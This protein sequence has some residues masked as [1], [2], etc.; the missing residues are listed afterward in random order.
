MDERLSTPVW[1]RPARR[2]RPRAVR[3]I[4]PSQRGSIAPQE[5]A[6]ELHRRRSQLIGELRRRSEARGV[7]AQ[8]Q[9]EI[10]DDAITAV[11]MSPRA[12]ANERHLLGA[13]WLAVAHRC[14]R[15]R[16][17]R[18]LT[19]LGSRR[20]VELDLAL[21]QAPTGMSPVDS[22]EQRERFARAADL[23]AELDE[24]ERAVFAAMASN[25]VGAVTAARLLEMP[26][27]E[28]RAAARSA[29]AKLDRVAAIAAAGRMCEFRA[30]AI[31]A[32]ASGTASERQARLAKAH[33]SACVPCTSVYRRLRREMRAREF[34]R[35]AVAAFLPLPAS[36][37]AHPAGLGRTLSWLEQRLHLLPR[38]G[39]DRTLE[40]LGGAGVAKAAV[41]GTAILAAGGALGGH[42]VGSLEHAPAH[43]HARSAHVASS[44][45]PR[46]A[47]VATPAP[48]STAAT[49][50]ASTTS[51]ARRVHVV[52]SAARAPSKSLGYLALGSSSEAGH[53]NASA[54]VGAASSSTARIASASA[55][56]T[57]AESAA[58]S[59]TA[60]PAP[61]EHAAPASSGGGGTALGY[62]G[63]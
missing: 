50:S 20:R 46:T 2:R 1:R 5:A 40:A 18:H 45:R 57:S 51:T 48:T 7:P 62:L 9:E 29:A 38:G 42:V 24:R 61:S 4:R 16:E 11:V 13:F 10:I 31:G 43:H 41:A 52:R 60:A 14:R 39:G 55:S 58:S 17:G 23:I 54:Q 44:A 8:A 3:V 56:A 33:L 37:A 30:G 22:L 26:L 63:Q 15:Y 12:I 32:Q 59:E 49:P 53:A 35:S 25:G 34:Q 19:R 28:A 27:G 47:A 21:E 36:A 6:A